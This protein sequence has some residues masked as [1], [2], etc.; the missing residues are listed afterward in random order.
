MTWILLVSSWLVLLLL[1]TRQ[2]GAMKR[3]DAA[4][5]GHQLACDTWPKYSIQGIRHQCVTVADLC[6]TQAVESLLAA[7]SWPVDRWID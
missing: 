3:A 4:N 7:A 5:V 2:L 1:A 6:A